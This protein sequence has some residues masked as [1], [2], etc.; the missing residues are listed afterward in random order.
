MKYLVKITIGFLV[1]SLALLYSCDPN[2]ELYEELDQDQKP[3]S[4]ETE[5]TLIDADYERFDGAISSYKAFNDTAPAMDYVPDVLAVRL[6]TLKDDSRANVTYN[7]Y[8]MHPYWWDS[9]FG[10]E[11]TEED[12]ENIQTQFNGF[13]E[14]EPSS[15]ALPS[16]LRKKYPDAEANDEA[17][18]I[19]NYLVISED[20][21]NPEVLEEYLYLDVYEY[22]GANWQ[23]VETIEE[24]PYVGYELT[25]DDYQSWDNDISQ[26]QSFS[27]TFP[28]EEY[29]PAFLKNMLPLAVEG[30]V[31]VLKYKYYDGGIV[32]KI[33]KFVFNGLKWEMVPYVEERTEQYVYG[34]L[35][36]AFDPT[37]VF[38]MSRDD[39]M[40]LAEVDPIPHETYDDF[41]YYYGA[42]A[43]YGNFDVRLLGR[44]LNTD[45][46]DNYSD[47]DLA[48]I[49]NEEG[50]EAAMD[51][52][53]RRIVE[54]GLIELL[55]YKF[56]DA[57]P[58][59][60][61]IDVHYIIKFETFAD[62]WIRGYPE[63][64]Y[65]CVEAGTPPQF[66]LVRGIEDPDDSEE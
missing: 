20:E 59:V 9:G 66:E 36:W 46:D 35:G 48:A 31:Q 55:Q 42:S 17:K 37:V 33:D 41:G 11:L 3:H 16:F 22:D 28:P 39:Y 57:V 24:I 52:M 6:Q 34:E 25:E 13:H 44:R 23:W 10:Y 7:H 56:P 64:E 53:L 5:Y 15:D 50:T 21:E 30:D 1:L 32:D 8:L 18:I 47:P 14:E 49:Y 65:V 45:D 19:Y 40:Y 63:V 58:Q 38:T 43:Y 60:G 27:E 61:G 2:K 51:E 29:L 26:N 12:Y 62:N 54:E 4:E